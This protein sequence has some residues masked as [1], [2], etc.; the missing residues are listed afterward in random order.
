MKK[1]LFAASTALAAIGYGVETVLVKG[2][3]GK[4]LRVNKSDFDADQAKDKPTYTEFKGDAENEVGGDGASSD[5]NVTGANGVQTTAAPSAPNFGGGPD[6]DPLPIDPVK[7]A[8]APSATT[9]DQL[10]VMKS[11]KKWFIA[12]G[13]G[14]KVTGDRAKLLGIEEGGY[15]SEEAAHRVQT[16][17]EPSKAPT[18]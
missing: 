1:I 4:G 14:N 5:V 6:S 9:A 17:T 10:L 12:D 13:M 16:T 2:Q 15:D 8:A 7:N 3:D 18:P 11:G